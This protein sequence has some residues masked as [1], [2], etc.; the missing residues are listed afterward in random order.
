M[1]TPNETTAPPSPTSN[2]LGFLAFP[3]TSVKWGIFLMVVLFV[4]CTVGSAGILYPSPT[5]WRH[6]MIRQYR[7][8]ELTE[9]EWFHTWFFYANIGLIC[10]NMACVTLLKIPF[11]VLKLGVWLIHTGIITLC[12]G[13]VIYFSTKVEGDAP[14]LRR[15]VLADVDGIEAPRMP[16]L[17]GARSAVDTPEG[18]YLFRVSSIEP[19]WPILSEADAGKK[20][21]AVNIE[22]TPPS[23]QPYVRQLLDGYPQY[24]EDVIPGQGRTRNIEGINRPI[25]DASLEMSLTPGVQDT[26]WIM[27]SFALYI[28][29][30]GTREWHMRPIPNLPRYN[31]YISSY[32]EIARG[33][34]NHEI[35][36]DPLDIVVPPKGAG[37]PLP[38]LPLRVTGYLRYA[39][40]E[41]TFADGG[42]ALN[43]VARMRFVFSDGTV[44]A[45]DLVAF[46]P[47]RRGALRD[48]IVFSWINDASELDGFRTP[49]LASL[50]VRSSETGEEVVLPVRRPT[51]GEEAGFRAVGQTGFDY[52]LI[53][54]VENLPMPNSPTGRV[55]LAVV[56]FR[57]PEGTTFTRWVFPDPSMNRDITSEADM[58]SHS[59]G[60]LDRRLQARYSPAASGPPLR[61]VAGPGDVGSYLI[62]DNTAL[63]VGGDEPVSVNPLTPGESLTLPAGLTIVLDEVV[64]N[65]R[66]ATRPLVIPRTQRDRNTETALLRSMVQVEIET[67]GRKGRTWLSFHGYSI[68]GP[69]YAPM[70]SGVYDPTPFELPGVGRFEILFSR[71]RRPLPTPVQLDDFVVT[72]HLG[73]LNPGDTRSIRDWTSRVSFVEGGAAV[74]QQSISTNKPAAHGGYWFFQRTWDPSGQRFTG[75]GVGNRNGVYTQLVGSCIAVLGMIYAFYVKPMI[76]RRRRERVYD[77]MQ[78]QEVAS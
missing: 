40:K 18:T 41:S 36:I 10:L 77:S 47:V 70:N 2:P 53:E 64:E 7:I 63:A 69:E 6:D 37:D 39:V 27:D 13:S 55:S 50:T 32:E 42:S 78:G 23:G 20:A 29:E 58:E 35:P 54:L 9:F 1:S 68:T 57:T 5:G 62:I 38:G 56:E 48:N 26:F 46:D 34:A 21:F 66:E 71:E 65:A 22:V 61:V 72:T 59:A 15:Y 76:R 31:E 12:V 51:V 16:A 25:I 44:Q 11:N 19:E 33:P 45:E 28:R 74:D 75:L 52:R 67:A 17:T 30:E 49:G 3:F 60:N 4:Y 24:T 73:G 43:P 8:F 14:V